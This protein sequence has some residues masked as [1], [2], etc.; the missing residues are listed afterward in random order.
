MKGMSIALLALIA[1]CFGTAVHGRLRDAQ[2]R[3]R[4][5][6]HPWINRPRPNRFPQVTAVIVRRPL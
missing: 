3:R 4:D 1:S 5:R 6:G 2:I